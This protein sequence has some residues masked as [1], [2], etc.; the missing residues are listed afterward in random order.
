MTANK[1]IFTGPVGAGKTTAIS[2]I[3]DVEPFCT[4]Q[5]ATD[6]T[7]DR[8]EMTTVAMDYG[9]LKLESGELI[10]LYG[11]PGQSRFDFM[12]DVLT[13]GGIG[14]VILIDNCRPNPLEDFAFFIN[15][16]QSF[17]SNCAAVVGI[18]RSESTYKPGLDDYWRITSELNLNIPILEVDPRERRDVTFLIQALLYSLDAGLS[19]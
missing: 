5:F 8:K 11:T 3:S 6:E 9:M 18:T 2:S 17:T 15:A 1:I 7:R 13:E 4:E 12:W 16:F 19:E 14:V 10:H